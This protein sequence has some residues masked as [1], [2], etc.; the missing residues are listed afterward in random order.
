MRN[1]STH[2]YLLALSVCNIFLLAGLTI[3]YAIK[4]IGKRA[5]CGTS[6]Q[7]I[8]SGAFASASM[9]WRA[10]PLCELISVGG[11]RETINALHF[12]SRRC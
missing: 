1:S 5:R 9:S 2:V 3:N 4:S 12:P 7:V 8:Y 10:L 11:L 6:Q